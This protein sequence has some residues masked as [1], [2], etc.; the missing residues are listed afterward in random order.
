M[1][2]N[3]PIEIIGDL[4]SPGDELGIFTLDGLLAGSAI[5]TG[6]TMVLPIWSDNEYTEEVDGMIAGEPFTIRVWNSLTGAESYLLVTCWEKGNGTWM[7]DELAIPAGIRVIA[8]VDNSAKFLLNIFPNPLSGPYIYLDFLLNEDAVL[9]IELFNI[10]G[11]LVQQIQSAK[12]LR[13]MHSVSLEKNSI[14]P[15]KYFLKVSGNG[16]S[17]TKPLIVLD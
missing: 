12:F 15:G 2:L 1:H 9:R 16:I 3:L 7:E 8:S 13:G 17:E 10:E 6:E 11:K 5:Y 14:I 4:L